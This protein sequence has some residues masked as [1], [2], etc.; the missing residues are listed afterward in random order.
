M[1]KLYLVTT[2]IG[3]LEDITLRAIETLKN[4]DLIYAEDTRTTHQLLARFGIKKP[5]DSLHDHNEQA[6][7]P[8]IITHLTQGKSIALVSESGTPLVSDPGYK[9]VRE[10]LKHGLEVESI[11]GP[12]ALIS[13]LVVSGLPPDRFFFTGFL[14]RKESDLKK[15]GQKIASF[16]KDLSFTFIAYESPFRIIKSLDVLGKELPQAYFVVARELTKLHEEVIR[17]SAHDFRERL[18]SHKLKGEIVVLIS[19]KNPFNAD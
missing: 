18:K 8:V 13:A 1:G 10:V 14:P 9:L 4:C 11:P 12:T 5:L 19:P 2:P 17:G 15:L 7:I 3:N 6:R 16:W